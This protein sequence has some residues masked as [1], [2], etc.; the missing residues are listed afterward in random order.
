MLRGK[1]A[2]FMRRPHRA[3]WLLPGLILAGWLAFP[4]SVDQAGL[5]YAA[6]AV[7]SAG[8]SITRS[9]G[10]LHAK[11][12]SAY[13][14]ERSILV[15]AR[16]LLIK[17]EE[18]RAAARE[19]R[20][21]EQQALVASN[22]RL[23]AGRADL[24][25]VQ[26]A[27]ADK[28]HGTLWLHASGTQ[29][30]TAWRA[31]VTLKAINWY[32][33]EYAPFVAGGLDRAPL[34]TILSNLRALGFNALRITFADQ[35]VEQ[36]PVVT[37]GL[38]AN[39]ELKGLRSLDV[40]DRIIKRAHHFGLRVV[41]CNSRSEGGRGPETMSGLWYTNRYSATAWVKDW[42]TLATRFRNESSFV[43][44]DLRNEPHI[45]GHVFDLNAYVQDGPQ[46]GPYHGVS[47][48]DRDWHA[49]AQSLGNALLQVNPRLLIIVEGVQ[50]YMDPKRNVLT[51][52][53]W[54]ANLIGVKYDPI[55]LSRPGQLVYSV[56]EYGPHMWQANWFNPTT[57]YDKLTHRW[58]SVWGYLLTASKRLQA[59]IFVGEFGTCHDY[60]ACVSDRLVWRQGFWFQS[61]VHFLSLHPQVG[62]AYW[63]LNPD[64]PFQPHTLNYYGLVSP[65]WKHYFPLVQQALGPL[66]RE[67][68]G[69][70]THR[71]VVLGLQPQ[72]GCFSNRSCLPGTNA[73]LGQQ[74]MTTTSTTTN[75][76][77]AVTSVTVQ[78]N[79]AYTLPADTRRAGDLYLPDN[80]TGQPRPAVVLLHGGTWEQGGRGPATAALA[81]RLARHG[82]VVYD[83]D[84]RLAGNGGEFPRDI[85]DVKAAAAYLSLN[86]ATLHID[87]SK[88]AIAGAG[89][90]GYLAVMAAYTPNNAPF[91]SKQY[92]AD[93]VHIAAVAS[94]FAPADL[95]RTG[96]DG[97]D[98]Q[99]LS[100]IRQYLQ[101]PYSMDPSIYD[102][103]SPTAYVGSGVPTIF[104]HGLSDSEAPF[105]QT[106]RLYR[107]LKQRAIHAELI[108]FHG[109]PRGFGA[110]TGPLGTEITTQM[111][112][113][114]DAAFYGP[115]PSSQRS[116]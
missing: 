55:V 9:A 2:H 68:T 54:G 97:S 23:I 80:S 8:L 83:A 64:G 112:G 4:F 34:D 85:R 26:R 42:I 50:I 27:A 62:W 19:L 46:W 76:P 72:P 67:P 11:A 88:I 105:Q 96:H 15:A 20:R 33:F 70:W 77:P 17:Q 60:Y 61:F 69:L 102:E 109:A 90:G 43:G 3:V 86:A 21:H 81:Y 10:T 7:Q 94:L 5:K 66:L 113:F 108:D 25:G 82:Y 49:A 104:F 92:A 103:A 65:D 35:T 87:A 63:A 56:H 74:M 53:L 89:A 116:R 12:A 45:I 44:A 1:M 75:V 107:Y 24:M 40:M 99:T 30:Y 111:E 58:N 29:L 36:D 101:A 78:K 57:T 6:P 38:D 52:G 73:V 28:L 79:V 41:L 14:S 37:S 51:G 47:Y 71:R 115:A 84:F 95:A 59:P 13:T 114:F 110:L 31:P 98:A 100:A 22:G 18:A 93:S 106:F 16:D 39:P 32:G 91:V 48:T